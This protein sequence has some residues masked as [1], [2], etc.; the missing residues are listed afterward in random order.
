MTSYNHQP[1][2]CGDET[3]PAW[4]LG[5]FLM[6]GLRRSDSG[7]GKCCPPSL[8]NRIKVQKR[9]LE[10]L[11]NSIYK[12]YDIRKF[13]ANSL[14]VFTRMIKSGYIEGCMKRTSDSLR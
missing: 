4:R 5:I 2:E 12:M 8:F 10:V 11:P 9:P 13:P 14:D 3:D 6:N 1:I 7:F